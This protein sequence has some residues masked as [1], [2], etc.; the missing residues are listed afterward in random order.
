MLYLLLVPVTRDILKL[1][2]TTHGGL[3]HL[4][5][6]AYKKGIQLGPSL[7]VRCLACMF[8]TLSFSA[9]DTKAL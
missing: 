7:Y 4:I 2:R 3:S 6:G 8:L 1:S 9:W 5:E